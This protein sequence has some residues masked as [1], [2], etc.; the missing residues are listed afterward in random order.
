ME[1]EDK[2][3]KIISNFEKESCG[4]LGKLEEKSKLEWRFSTNREDFEGFSGFMKEYFWR[5]PKEIFK[6]TSCLGGDFEKENEVFK[7]CLKVTKKAFSGGAVTSL[8][9]N[10]FKW[11]DKP[12]INEDDKKIKKVFKRIGQASLTTLNTCGRILYGV[13]AIPL[14]VVS[15]ASKGVSYSLSLFGKKISEGKGII[16]GGPILVVA[17][18][19]N[20]VSSLLSEP[21]QRMLT[22]GQY[23]KDKEDKEDK[24]DEETTYT[25]LKKWHQK[26]SNKASHLKKA[27]ESLEK[28]KE[29]FKEIKGNIAIEEGIKDDFN[30]KIK[31]CEIKNKKEE[32]KLAEEISKYTISLN[33]KKLKECRKSMSNF[34][35]SK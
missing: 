22:Y 21:Y 27:R 31:S 12:K 20:G 16:L 30:E 15:L 18:L 6:R 33:L 7:R 28:I 11:I 1:G 23:E 9:K 34:L 17:T 10:T 5:Q 4:A 14:Q 29:N 8:I 32:A 26:L 19:L 3:E 25:S 2:N 35:N 24:E 13:T